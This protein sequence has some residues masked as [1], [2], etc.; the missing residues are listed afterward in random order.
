MGS[1]SMSAGKVRRL[2]QALIDGTPSGQIQREHWNQGWAV[3]RCL[4]A[5]VPLDYLVPLH[6]AEPRMH[7]STQRIAWQ[8][9]C[10]FG[11]MC[12]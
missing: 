8:K 9:K 10:R 4:R 11:P 5:M 1:L 2:G 6:L 7:A 12:M 3:P